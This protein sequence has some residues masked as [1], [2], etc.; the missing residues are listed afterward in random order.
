[1]NR[2]LV[3]DLLKIMA[4]QAIVV[5]HLSVYGPMADTLQGVWPVAMDA[6]FA[7]SR[8][9]VQVFL[10]IG[11]FLA[12]QAIRFDGLA[13]SSSQVWQMLWRRYARLIPPYL[14]ALTVISFLVWLCR[15]HI[16]GDWL[17]DAPTWASALA[18][19][20]TLQNIL[21]LPSLSAGVWYVAMDFQLYVLLVLLVAAARTPRMLSFAVAGLCAASMLYFNRQTHLDNWSLYFIGSYGLGVLASWSRRCAFSARLFVGMVGVALLALWIAPRLRLEVALATAVLLSMSTHWRT[22]AHGLGQ[23]M[24]RLADSSYGTFLTHYGVI[25]VVSAMWDLTHRSGVPWSLAA[26][27][28]VW[29]L[30]VGTGMA[31]HHWVEQ[32]LSRR[33]SA[34]WQRQRA[35]ETAH[36]ATHSTPTNLP[37]PPHT[38]TPQTSPR[39]H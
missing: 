30:S 31:F 7:Y 15:S 32:P 37:W 20:V 27:V 9:A 1:M 33:V 35:L 13:P 23:W 39:L 17:V 29:L 25:V 38:R 11:G 2:S 3:I 28:A 36:S 4:A 19:A 26:S 12:A 24:Q 8:L 5:H 34:F 22:P 16:D 10:V 14:L 6:L 18:H 21:G